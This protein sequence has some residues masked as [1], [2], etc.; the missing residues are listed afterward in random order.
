MDALS[1]ILARVK[2]EHGTEDAHRVRDAFDGDAPWAM[3]VIPAPARGPS[4][5]KRRPRKGR[6]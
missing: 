2:A 4:L 5:R 3:K 1:D 6:R